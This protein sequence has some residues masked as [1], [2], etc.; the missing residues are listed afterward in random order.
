VL[1]PEIHNYNA[2]FYLIL[3]TNSSG[4]FLAIWWIERKLQHGLLI[5]SIAVFTSA[6]LLYDP[7]IEH[8]ILL[9]RSIIL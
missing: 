7:G 2:A 9:L 6:N 4:I 1:N 3:L 5:P 8:Q